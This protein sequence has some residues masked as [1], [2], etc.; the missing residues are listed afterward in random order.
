[1]FFEY[2]FNRAMPKF[3]YHACT[4]ILIIVVDHVD[5]CSG[6]RSSS[7]LKE[8]FIL[9]P[10]DLIVL[11]YSLKKIAFQLYNISCKYIYDFIFLYVSRLFDFVKNK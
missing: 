5:S 4:N 1:M 7:F 3:I 10:T 6:E 8:S 2:F 9:F 11:T